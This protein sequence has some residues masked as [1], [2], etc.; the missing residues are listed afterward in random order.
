MLE[1]QALVTRTDEQ[2]VFIKSLQGSA[3]GHCL[4][5][6]SCATTHYAH[7]LPDR[8]MALSSPL[9]LQAGDWVIVGIEE[10]QL[11]RASFIMYLLPLLLLLG[12]VGLSGGD[13]QTTVPLAVATLSVSYY[14][15]YRLQN[16]FI[17]HL[18]SPPQIL[19][20]L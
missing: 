3:C 2:K 18:I 1:Q 16:G 13:D 6:Q 12:I 8:E 20:K 9:P 11:L 4:K 15:F 7:L 5:R 19:R 10:N 17:R 14:L